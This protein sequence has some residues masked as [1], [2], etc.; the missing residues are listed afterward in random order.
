[1]SQDQESSLKT[2]FKNLC[3]KVKAL[4]NA[5]Q[6]L[7]L[8]QS[9]PRKITDCSDSEIDEDDIFPLNNVDDLKHFETKLKT[10]AV[11]RKSLVCP[12]VFI[13]NCPLVGKFN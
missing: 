11:F 8:V 5:F 4:E 6:N 9:T 1:M 12:L 7:L 10:N 3:E 13:S 2:D